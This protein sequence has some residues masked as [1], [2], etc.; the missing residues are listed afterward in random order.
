MLLDLDHVSKI[1][2]DLHALDDLNLSVPQGQ[3]LAVVGSSGSGKTTLMNILGCMDTP[4]RGSV[5]LQGR[6]LEDLSQSQL[7]DV[8]KN[9]IGLVFQKFYLVPHLTALENVMVAQY[10][11]SVV[12]EDQAMKALD[13]VGLA[14]RARHLPSQLSGGEQQRVCVARALIN[15]PKLI[16]ADEPTGNL[17]EAN[18]RIVLDL[19]R[20]LHD[21]GT[22]L[23]VVTH[24]ALVASCAQREIMLNHGVLA[25]E[26]WNDEEAKRAYLAAGGRPAFSGDPGDSGDQDIPVGFHDP[27]KTAKTGGTLPGSAADAEGGR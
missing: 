22:S 1:Y 6:P 11:H 13:R 18:E 26:Q 5:R 19:F 10:Y 17:D 25:G 14:D 21:Q 20:Q 9:V 23:I 15:E 12:D 2:G 16:L 4:S 24:D 7:A 3:W 27:T 8:R